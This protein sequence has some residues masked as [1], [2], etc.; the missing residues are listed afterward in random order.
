[1]GTHI[2]CRCSRN[3]SA[4]GSS[5]AHQE[6]RNTTNTTDG[7]GRPGNQWDHNM[8]NLTSI[9]RGNSTNDE[10]ERLKDEPKRCPC[11]GGIGRWVCVGTDKEEEQDDGDEH[12][13]KG[14]DEGDEDEQDGEGYVSRDRQGE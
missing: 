7:W 13:D 6:D 11:E 14:N 10:N 8:T 4:W 5:E 2:G 9:H 1:M 3:A 12:E